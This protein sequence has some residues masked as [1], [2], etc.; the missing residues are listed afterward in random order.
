ML[1][2]QISFLIY[3]TYFHGLLGKTLPCILCTAAHFIEFICWS[4][5][6]FCYF[7]AALHNLLL[8]ANPNKTFQSAFRSRASDCYN[9]LFTGLLPFLAF[10]PLINLF[11]LVL[12]LTFTI[13][14]FYFSWPP[15][16]RYQRIQNELHANQSWF[17]SP[18]H[19]LVKF[20][21]YYLF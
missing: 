13:S 17:S 12:N 15:E 7:D 1:P 14:P 19:Q 9:I 21:M 16:S 3:P 18:L 4:L 20:P 5:F 10:Q 11:C 6:C 2:L 8:S